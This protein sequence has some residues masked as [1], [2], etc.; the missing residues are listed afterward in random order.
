[1]PRWL[2]HEGI[3]LLVQYPQYAKRWVGSVV[4]G[5]GN[6]VGWIALIWLVMRITGSAASVG[7]VTLLY[8]VPQ[9]LVAPFA[10]VLLD[11]YPRTRVMALANLVLGCLFTVIPIV[12]LTAG[13]RAIWEIY[14]MIALA[15]VILPFDQ[16]GAGPLIAE[17]IPSEKLSQANFLAQTV[18]QLSYLLGPGLGGFLITILGTAPLLFVDAATFFVLAILVNTIPSNVNM[19]AARTST[20]WTN[21]REGMNYLLRKPPLIAMAILTVLFNFFYGP[22]EVI[23][24]A[25]AKS[26]Y[27][28]PQALGLLW[29]VF[30][31]GSLLGSLVFSNRTWKYRLSASLASVIVLWG[32][33]TL[34]MAFA[35]RFV[36]AALIMFACGIIFSPWGPLVSTARQRIVP[37]QML[38]RV[39]GASQSITAL[40]TPFGAWATGLILPFVRTEQIML[41][42]GAVT[43]LVGIT[44]FV[45]PAFRGVD[46]NQY[47]APGVERPG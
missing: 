37:M 38:G 1:M 10:G 8:Q 20:P 29:T 9:A 6:Q 24:P 32:V 46:R 13:A 35:T 4:S 33:A 14:A 18:W 43:I 15:G 23:L 45:W 17:L 16:T 19:S 42:S 3:R 40:G 22:Y 5:F 28:G 11:R 41:L 7:V 30:A 44:G 12:A 36:W 26:E 25:L 34:G 47:N 39:S 27:G 21:L 31:I 2:Q